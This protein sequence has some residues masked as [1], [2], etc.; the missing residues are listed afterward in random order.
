[1]SICLDP[2]VVLG[3][4]APWGQ[5]WPSPHPG[6]ADHHT[7]ILKTFTLG[8][9]Q[10]I[11]RPIGEVFSFFSDAAN[12]QAITP[13]WVGFEIL[14]K[15]PIEMRQGTLIDYRIRIHRVP[16]RW[17]TEITVWEPPVR[18]V[19]V[20]RRGPYRSWVHTHEFESRDGGTLC[21]DHVE[22]AVPGGALIHRLFVR[23]DVE[24]IFAFRRAALASRFGG[25]PTQ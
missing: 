4:D 1:L 5:G 22:Y 11:P 17:R 8:A 13:S 10:W 2:G 20:Q 12:L 18:F 14:T 23:A 25:S 19:D 3:A 21:R 7:K 6:I 9:Q 16:L 15:G 24:K